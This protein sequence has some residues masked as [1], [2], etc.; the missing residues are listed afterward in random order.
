MAFGF[1]VLSFCTL[2]LVKAPVTLDQVR[3][4]RVDNIVPEGAMGFGDLGI[5]PASLEAVLPSYLWCFRPS[6]QYDAIKESAKN[7]RPE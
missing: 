6:G 2:G 4:L 3:N 7:L 5:K 1:G